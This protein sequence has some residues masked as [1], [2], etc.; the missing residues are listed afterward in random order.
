MSE[1]DIHLDM[2]EAEYRKANGINASSLKK[3]LLSPAHF[4]YAQE[5]EETDKRNANLIVGTLVHKSRL[6]PEKLCYAVRPKEFKDWRT[7]ESQAWR[8]AQTLPVV[9]PD[10]E[11]QVKRCADALFSIDLLSELAARGNTEVTAFK[12]HERTGLLMKGRADLLSVDDDGNTWV[13]DIKTVPE[14]GASS[15]QFSRKIAEMNYHLQAAFYCDL[16][17]T[18]NFMFVAV[19][20]SGF[21]GV[22]VY[23]LDKEDIELGRRTNEALIQKLALCRKENKWPGYPTKP[24]TINLPQWKRKQEMGDI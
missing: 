10:E 9:T 24:T 18:N 2:P 22:G 3:M 7:K 20:K 5:E 13:I 1:T 15:N 14:E 4:K 21:T 16:F 17:G 11:E 23:I 19:E 12:R 6:E 8:D